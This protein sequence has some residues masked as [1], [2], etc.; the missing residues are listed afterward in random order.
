MAHYCAENGLED[1]LQVFVWSSDSASERWFL[2]GNLRPDVVKAMLRGHSQE[3]LKSKFPRLPMTIPVM[4]LLKKI[5]SESNMTKWKKPTLWAIC[6]LAFHGS[7]RI[8]ELLSKGDGS[9]DPT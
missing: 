3:N 5:L 6:A 1:Y 7:F 9:Y 4:K 8:Y 2:P